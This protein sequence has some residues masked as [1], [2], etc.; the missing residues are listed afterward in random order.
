MKRLSWLFLMVV[1]ILSC[2]DDQDGQSLKEVTN[3]TI[4]IDRSALA[5][6]AHHLS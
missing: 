5:A 2:Q 3:E 6:R 1:L 4:K